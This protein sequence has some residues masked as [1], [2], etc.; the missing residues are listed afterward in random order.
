MTTRQ[1]ESQVKVNVDINTLSVQ[2][3]LPKGFDDDCGDRWII[4][5]TSIKVQDNGH[6]YFATANYRRD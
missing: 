3:T 6:G 1:V 4:D 5:W 2:T